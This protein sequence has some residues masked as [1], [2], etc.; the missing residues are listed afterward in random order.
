MMQAVIPAAG[1]GTRLHPITEDRTKAMCPIAGKPMVARVMDTLAANGADN[2]ILVVS[3]KDT[4]IAAYFANDPA[5]R[6]VEQ[7]H[8]LGMGHALLQAAPYIE[9]DFILS[10]CDS[11]VNEH[12]ILGMLRM[13]VSVP[14]PNAVLALLRVGPADLSRMGVVELDGERVIRIIEKPGPEAAPSDLGSPPLYLFSTKLLDHLQAMRPSQR[15]EYELQD[16]I[17][18]LIEHEGEVYGHLIPERID[19]TRPED[20]LR[21]NLRYLKNG[22]PQTELVL[23]EVGKKSRFVSPVLIE[24]DVSIGEGCVIG[25]NVFIEREARI[26]HGV[27]L[28]NCVVLRGAKVGEGT[29]AK[30]QVFW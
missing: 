17:Q 7:S 14:P 21:L 24:S 5:V 27:Q 2:F 26:G 13:W 30:N 20:L 11:L 22:Q 12:A 9:D 8:P 1:R 18:A 19:L 4:E 3:P 28:E 23:D 29:R 10:A 16:A 15:G 25:P 6:L